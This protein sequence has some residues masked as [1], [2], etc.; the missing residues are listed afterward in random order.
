MARLKSVVLAD[1]Q[2][3]QNASTGNRGKRVQSARVYVC[4]VDVVGISTAQVGQSQGFYLTKSVEIPQFFYRSEKYLYFDGVLYEVKMLSRA[5]AAANVL[6]NVQ[7]A[8]DET[9]KKAVEDW[10][11][12]NL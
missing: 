3:V 2:S 10:M 8:N 4:W 9:I 11:H 7:K 12:E 6:L 5:R 1:V